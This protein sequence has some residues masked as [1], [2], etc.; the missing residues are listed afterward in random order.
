M[1]ADDSEINQQIKHLLETGLKYV[2]IWVSGPLLSLGVGLMQPYVPFI[3]VIAYVSWMILALIVVIIAI[4]GLKLVWGHPIYQ[5]DIHPFRALLFIGLAMFTL[6]T[7]WVTA[8]ILVILGDA[9]F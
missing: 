3:G 4:K 7:C 8:G 9:P 5:Q 2:F 1:V 6:Q